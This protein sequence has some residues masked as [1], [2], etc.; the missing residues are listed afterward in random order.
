MLR[1]DDGVLGTN[2]AARGATLAA[3]IRLLD[4]NCFHLVHAVDAEQAKVDALHAVG[5]AGVVDDR[6]PAARSLLLDSKWFRLG[7]GFGDHE[8]RPAG[9]FAQ[10]WQRSVIRRRNKPSRLVEGGQ[11]GHSQTGKP[12]E[13]QRVLAGDPLHFVDIDLGLFVNPKVQAVDA[14]VGEIPRVDDTFFGI[15]IRGR[16]L[17]RIFV[18]LVVFIGLDQRQPFLAANAEAVERPADPPLVQPGE[19]D[20]VSHDAVQSQHAGAIRLQIV[21]VRDDDQ[22]QPLLEE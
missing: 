3:V 16:F 17:F 7:L 6:I 15:A 4:Q 18:L 19:N 20:H 5:A 1:E 9:G 14:A 2:A 11:P 13:R 10:E 21:E 22:V 12:H 8:R